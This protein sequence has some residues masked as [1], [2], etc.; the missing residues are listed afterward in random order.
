MSIEQSGYKITRHV[1]PRNCY[2]ACGMVAYTKNG[3]LKK[4][5]GDPA[6]EYTK[7]KLCA[8]GYSYINRVYHRDRIKYPLLQEKRGS[9]KWKRIS[10]NKALSLIASK[11]IELNNRYGSNLSICLNKYSGNFGVLHN[12]VEGFFN[13]LG[14]TTRVIGSPCWS[15]GLDA[16]YYDFGSYETSDPSDIQNAKL[17]ILWGVNPA[18][19]AVHSL[20]YIYQ[21]QDQ[22]AKVIVIDPIQTIT[23][24]KA[25]KY[26]QIRP[27]GDGALAIAIAKI[28]IE[29]DLY[30][31]SF[32][33]QYTLGW[34]LFKEYVEG[35]DMS[36]L[37]EQCDV[38]EE[39]ISSLA[40]QIGT[41]K[42]CFI[43]LGFGMQRHSNGGQNIRAIDALCAMT[44]NIGL[45]GGGV[46]FAQLTT[47]KYTNDILNNKDIENRIIEI[48][49]FSNQLKEL[50]DPPIKFLWV[51]CRNLLT[52]DPQQNKTIESLRELEMIV[53]VDHFLTA[54]ALQSDIVLP[55]TTHFEEEDIVSGYWHHIVGINEKAIEPYF[56]SK[57]DLE[58]AKAL[59]KKLNQES[60]G[61]SS[62]ATSGDPID[63]IEREFNEDFYNLLETEHW[64][65]LK[66]EPKR[67]NIPKTAWVDREF[68]TP[69]TKYEFYS[70]RA[71]KDG[72]S[73]LPQ[74]DRGMEPSQKYPYWLL[75]PHSQF[76]LNSQFQNLDWVSSMNP[77]P[78]VYLNPKLAEKKN[79]D[80]NSMIK[81]FNQFGEV[82]VKIKTTSD[83]PMDT[84]LFYQSWFPN[85]NLSI[86]VLVPGFPTDMGKVST[87]SRGIAFYDAFVDFEKV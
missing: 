68:K 18:W 72:F 75:T 64:S 28:L 27:G 23:A 80:N 8:K 47:W 58:I 66:D 10:W 74:F 2:G 25:D 76:G 35:L 37:I 33:D 41:I 22:G 69:S 51:S 12:A 9:G 16:Q 3:I 11:I 5:D 50:K 73:P 87:G 84:I 85:S 44:G 59:S 40:K 46:N 39:T 24:K 56:E 20:P 31:Q 81:V 1:C 48:N 49:E 86:N 77:E 57:S 4:V 61:F 36:E 30:D 53:T 7:G 45:P 63:F 55:A 62:F 17:I 6:H 38:N 15:A 43:W 65:K 26:V 19:T 70:E 14:E 32:I 67:A 60:P 78:Y 29:N 42:P 21:A 71:K 52:Q 83:V 13:G 82:I 34:Q 79:I 54:T